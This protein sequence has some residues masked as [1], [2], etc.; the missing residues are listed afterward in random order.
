MLVEE[1]RR[2]ARVLANLLELADKVRIRTVVEIDGRGNLRGSVF[3]MTFL[4]ESPETIREIQ[5]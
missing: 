2:A 1:S 4:D 3:V 5:S